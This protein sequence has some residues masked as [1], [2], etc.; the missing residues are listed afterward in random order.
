MLLAGDIGGTKA[1]LALVNPA[2]GPREPVAEEEF[3]S[4]AYPGMEALLRDFLQRHPARLSAACLAVAGPVVDGVATLTNL[5]WAVREQELAAA[6]RL[7]RVRL[8]N[9]LQALAAATPHLMTEDLVTLAVGQPV[10]GGAIA[11]I[12]PGT[13]L[14]EAFLTWDGTRYHAHPSEG[15]HADFAPANDLQAALRA[16]LAQDGSHVSYERVCSGQG[17]P[18]LYAFLRARGLPEP[19]WLAARLAAAPDRTAVIIRAAVQEDPPQICRE[20]VELFIDILA[21]EAGN[22]ALKVLA[23]GGV[24]IGGGIPPR[25]LDWLTP[26]RVL[27]VFRAKGRLSTLMAQL[28]LHVIVNPRAGLLGAAYLE[29]AG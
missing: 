8:V 16:F 10:R 6:L 18:T 23:T 29:L 5:P 27:P 20:T 7:R 24:F 13:G 19:A 2:T 14:G 4:G 15:G 11:V 25:L 12:A 22:L 28:P 17:I 21:A 26:E 9:D 3:T 1:R